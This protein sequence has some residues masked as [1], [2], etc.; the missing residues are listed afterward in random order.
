M[1]VTCLDL[2]PPKIP[3][4]LAK[5]IVMSKITPVACDPWYEWVNRDTQESKIINPLHK[6]FNHMFSDIQLPCYEIILS[7]SK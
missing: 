2:I 3:Y 7:L 4:S 1:Y 5:K 6:N